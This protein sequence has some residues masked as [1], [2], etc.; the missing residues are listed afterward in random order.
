MTF[1]INGAKRITFLA[2]V[3]ACVATTLAQS[4]R[5]TVR[6]YVAFEDLSYIEVGERKVNAKIELRRTTEPKQVVRTTETD[7]HGLYELKA[8]SPGEYILRISSAGYR[9]YETEI[10]LPS[11]F[12]CNLAVM[13]KKDKH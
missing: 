9:P 5:S 1:S 11:D 7:E 2:I 4:G 13:L 10:Y 12:V 6:G 8:V 3:A